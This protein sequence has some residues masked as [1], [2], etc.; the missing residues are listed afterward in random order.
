MAFIGCLFHHRSSINEN[1][2]QFSQFLF[3]DSLNFLPIADRQR[4]ESAEFLWNF[5]SFLDK[6]GSQQLSFLFNIFYFYISTLSTFR[7]SWF[8]SRRCHGYFFEKKISVS[9]DGLK[10][11]SS[12]RSPRARPTKNLWKSDVSCV[13]WGGHYNNKTATKN[14]KWRIWTAH[15]KK[16]NKSQQNRF[17]QG[18]NICDWVE[19]NFKLLFYKHKQTLNIITARHYGEP[20]SQS[21]ITAQQPSK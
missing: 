6:F 8:E 16:I 10:N 12:V 4:P 17:L 13:V 9:L 3:S 1:E 15:T 18:R 21:T 7:T 5:M 19:Y 2:P 11:G 20:K 14:E